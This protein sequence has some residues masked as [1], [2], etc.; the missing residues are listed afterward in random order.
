MV[1]EQRDELLADHAGR[2]EYA[3][4]DRHLRVLRSLSCV[5]RSKKKA[6]AVFGRSAVDGSL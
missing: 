3:N 1:C 5:S 4:F 6:D 2:A